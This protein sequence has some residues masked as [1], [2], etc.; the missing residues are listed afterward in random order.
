MP[1]NYDLAKRLAATGQVASLGE[2]EALVERFEDALNK[3]GVEVQSGS[4]LE[5]ACLSVVEV[6]G[7]HEN[8]ELRDPR[9]N[10][11][12]VF[13]ELLGVWIFLTKVV[14]LQDHPAFAQFKPHLKLLNEGTV[15]QHTRLRACEEATNKIFE[16]LFAL[17]LLDIGNDLV[18]DPPDLARGDNPDILVTL[19]GQRWGFA[20]K[21]VYGQSGKTFFDN[22]KRGVDQIEV[23]EATVG[24]V[25][26]NFRNQLDHEAFWPVLNPDE[27]RNGAEPILGA[28]PNPELMGMELCRQVTVKRDQIASE[29][30][31]SNVLNIFTG[32]KA[33]PGFLAFCQTIAA[34]ATSVGPVPSLISALVL[35]NFNRCDSHIRVFQWINEALHERA[36]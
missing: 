32:K 8:P 35:G 21:T 11:R 29:I 10:V 30:G 6:L 15:V 9:E 31:L 20:C 33:V 3:Y 4:E 16:L 36:H 7:K 22:L 28:F 34:K 5:A 24:C 12:V 23:S 27:H 13:A 25:M 14:R 17:V 26:V 2:L 19:V 1:L 18:L